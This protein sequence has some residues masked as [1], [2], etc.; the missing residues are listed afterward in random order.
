MRMTV[1]KGLPKD[2]KKIVKLHM[3]TRLAI[4]QNKF[5]LTKPMIHYMT[6]VE[7]RGPEAWCHGAGRAGGAVSRLWKSLVLVGFATRP[8]HKLTRAGRA[9][10]KAAVGIKYTAAEMKLFDSL[11]AKACNSHSQMD[12]ITGRFAL[13][14][15]LAKHGRAKCDYMLAIVKANDEARRNGKRP[16]A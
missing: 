7:A 8:P 5:V 10:L 16:K 14:K 3:G 6:A 4:A 15:F 1:L 2:M 11:T 12:R 9:A 13:D